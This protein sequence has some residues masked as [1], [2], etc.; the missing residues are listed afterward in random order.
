MIE[1]R[2]SFAGEVLRLPARAATVRDFNSGEALP[3][4][5]PGQFAL[6]AAKGRLL[7]EVPGFFNGKSEAS[8]TGNPALRLRA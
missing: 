4:I 1:E 2:S 6:P 3:Q 8:A 5:A 7:L